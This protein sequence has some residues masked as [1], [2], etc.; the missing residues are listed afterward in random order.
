[1]LFRSGMFSPLLFWLPLVFLSLLL[2]QGT[3]LSPSD[4]IPGLIGLFIIMD[5]TYIFLL[6]YDFWNDFTTAR[7]RVKLSRSEDGE[8][9]NL[10]LKSINSHLGALK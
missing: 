10:L 5:L 7:R 2:L 4:I 1:M 6:G 9:L 3:A 8:K